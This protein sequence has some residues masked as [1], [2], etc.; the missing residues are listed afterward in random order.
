MFKHKA[1]ML[2][3]FD[4]FVR[5]INAAFGEARAALVREDYVGAQRIL[6]SIAVRHAKASLSLR[7]MLIKNG[8]LEEDK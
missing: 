2:R 7:N 4:K 1:A 8:K 6:A 5:G 3:G